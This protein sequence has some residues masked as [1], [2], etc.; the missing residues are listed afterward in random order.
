[1]NARFQHAIAL[2]DEQ[3]SLDPN[4][5]IINGK[6]IPR[7]VLYSQRLTE[8]I[9]RL[10]PE[11]S[12]ALLLA[13]RSQHI[14]RWKIPRTDYPVTRPGYHQWKNDLKRFHARLSGEILAQAGYDEPIIARVRSLNLK[15]GFPNDP[16]TRTLEDALCLMF[17]EYQFAPLA[18][19]AEASKV[20]N[21]LRKSW[22]KMTEPARK[23]ALTLNYE[24]RQKALL[25]TA[26]EADQAGFLS[27]SGNRA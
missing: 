26:L 4:T 15:E 21:A 9:I 16:E 11:A 1:M 18:E 10:N 2:I 22:S 13:A 25:A 12:E 7:E 24:S 6:S 17:L 20:V 5:E 23:A 8:W 14:C 3:N 27:G 19:K